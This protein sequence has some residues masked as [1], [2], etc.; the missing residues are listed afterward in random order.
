MTHTET[1][2]WMAQ[3]PPEQ[4]GGEGTQSQPGDTEQAEQ[5]SDTGQPESRVFHKVGTGI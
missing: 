4:E 2:L 1:P 3:E 5:P